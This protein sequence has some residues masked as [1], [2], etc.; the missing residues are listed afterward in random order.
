MSATQYIWVEKYLKELSEPE[1][2]QAIFHHNEVK[3]LNIS[4]E[5]WDKAQLKGMR[6]RR[7]V[8]YPN[9]PVQKSV[10]SALKLEED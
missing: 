1:V 9:G 10:M 4:E 6:L 8:D 3:T 7:M 2:K 5:I